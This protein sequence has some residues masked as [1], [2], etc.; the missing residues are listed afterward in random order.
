ME[1]SNTQESKLQAENP[2]VAE[3]VEAVERLKSNAEKGQAVSLVFTIHGAM[4]ISDTRSFYATIG[5]YYGF[6]STPTKA[7]EAAV[8][9]YGSYM[10]RRN[11]QILK[12]HEEAAKLGFTV[13]ESGA[14]R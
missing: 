14:T 12:L 13:T 7:M 9:N 5:Q 1:T 4:E 8:L 6:G 10:D 3:M 11:E 2:I